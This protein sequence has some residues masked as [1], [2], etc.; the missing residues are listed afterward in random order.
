[1]AANPWANNIPD[2][3]PDYPQAVTSR[4]AVPTPGSRQDDAPYNDEFG[5]SP[6]PRK[7]PGN[8][9]DPYRLGTAPLIQHYPAP[10]TPPQEYYGGIDADRK[11][12]HSVESVDAD[13]WEENKN[14]PSYPSAA[15]GANRFARNPRETPP[16]ESRITQRL[17]PRSY[18]FMRPFGTNTRKVGART[19]NG[20]HFSMADHSRHY[21]ILGMRPAPEKR[22]TYRIEPTPWDAN[23]VDMP[24]QTEPSRMQV[25]AVD[26]PYTS[27][28]WRLT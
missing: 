18:T 11:T 16:A 24:V 6:H 21:E 10:G 12:R 14:Y 15:A 19:F 22:N 7:V 3:T 8:T 28:S 9:P 26:V 20:L 13:G 2:A 4:Y 17:A 25:A 5:W 1:M 23:I 27:R